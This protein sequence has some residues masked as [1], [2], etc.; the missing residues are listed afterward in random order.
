MLKSIYDL[1]A[2]DLQGE[3]VSLKD[4]KGKV[5]LIVNIASQCG[6]TPQLEAL[7]NVYKKYRAKGFEILAF[8]CNQFAGQEP[9]K[10][11]AIQEFCSMEYGISFRIMEKTQVK[12]PSAHPVFKFLSNKA[13]NGKVG[14]SPMWNFQKYLVDRNGMVMDYFMPFT[15][16]DSSKVTKAIEALL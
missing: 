5:L 8:P 4:Y 15:R 13:E 6:F 9:L 10:N 16:P 3:A 7:E 14:L 11:G 2:Q 12:G 1:K